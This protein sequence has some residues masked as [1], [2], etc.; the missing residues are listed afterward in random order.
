[1]PRS[2][3]FPTD[4][5]A[6]PAPPVTSPAVKKYAKAVRH[7]R[8][9]AKQAEKEKQAAAIG[10][11]CDGDAIDSDATVGYE[12]GDGDELENPIDLRGDDSDSDAS[13]PGAGSDH[14][15]YG[16]AADDGA[17]PMPPMPT[18]AARAARDAH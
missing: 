18:R 11:L 17:P 10:E 16:G 3:L 13:A 6:P 9:K 1:M 7:Q 2:P 14:D 15:I 4:C 12:A 5:P 8:R